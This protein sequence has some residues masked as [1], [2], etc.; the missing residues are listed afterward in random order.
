VVLA[1]LLLLL[2]VHLLKVL[3]RVRPDLH[4]GPGS[5]HP[6]DRLPLLP[7]LLQPLQEHD[8]LGLGPPSDLLAVAVAVV[9]AAVVVV[10]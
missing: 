8:V 10:R 5:D 7:V 1:L 9:V 6:C 4:H 2:P 3:L